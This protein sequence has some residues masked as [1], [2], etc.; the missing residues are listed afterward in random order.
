MST[1]FHT[2][3]DRLAL[4]LLGCASTFCNIAHSDD[5]VNKVDAWEKSCDGSICTLSLYK[6][7]KEAKGES[8]YF[9]LGLRVFQQ[10]G[11]PDYF[12]FSIPPQAQS[13]QVI[14]SFQD[15]EREPTRIVGKEITSFLMKPCAARKDCKF[16][17]PNAVVTPNFD[18]DFKPLNVWEALHARQLLMIKMV[19][20]VDGARVERSA[21][22]SLPAFKHVTSELLDKK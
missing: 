5:W 17:F 19:S 6:D 13:S 18:G 21:L 1:P 2:L 14:L 11:K 4:L 20:R 10:S 3:S 22:I 16:V 7:M 12:V 9:A 15:L 8:D